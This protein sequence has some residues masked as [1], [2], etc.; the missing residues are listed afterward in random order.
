[1][2]QARRWMGMSL[3]EHEVEQD[4]GG[5]E[6]QRGRLDERQHGGLEGEGGLWVVIEQVAQQIHCQ[7]SFLK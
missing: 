4:Q 3:P 7:L 2:R 6:Q 5:T 1:M